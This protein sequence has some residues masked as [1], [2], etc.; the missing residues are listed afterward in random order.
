MRSVDV[1]TIRYVAHNIDNV[2]LHNTIEVCLDELTKRNNKVVVEVVR[3]NM[4]LTDGCRAQ[5]EAILSRNGYNLH[6]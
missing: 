3:E 6:I 4:K 1:E 2:A 5:T